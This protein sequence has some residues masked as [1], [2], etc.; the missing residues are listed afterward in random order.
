MIQRYLSICA[1]DSRL[2]F[3]YLVTLSQINFGFGLYGWCGVLH[4]NCY[5]SLSRRRCRI[6][7]VVL[8]GRLLAAYDIDMSEA[9][10]LDELGELDILLLFN[11]CCAVAKAVS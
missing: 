4:W 1:S 2:W 11:V 7:G 3:D 8:D 5:L 10:E 6:G 9:D